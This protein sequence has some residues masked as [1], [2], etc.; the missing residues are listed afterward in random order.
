MFKDFDLT[1]TGI[2][3]YIKYLKGTDFIWKNGDL[4]C[5][6]GKFWEKDDTLMR[7]YIGS[8][9]Y[10]FLKNVL[11]TCFWDDKSFSQYKT[12]LDKLRSLNFKKEIIETTKECLTNNKID[13]DSKYYL[14]GFDNMVYDLNENKF[15]EYNYDD[16]ISITTG[17]GWIK[18][19]KEQINTIEKIIIL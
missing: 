14:F 19:E 6:N 1:S 18:P 8:E 9:L 10:N 2:A 13:F 7:I 4:Y 15:R 16:Y 3:N 5:F 17:Y 11:A 12:K